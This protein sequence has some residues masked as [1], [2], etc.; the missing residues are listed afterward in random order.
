MGNA[1]LGN[2]LPGKLCF[3][4]LSSAP[5][6]K[7]PPWVGVVGRSKRLEALAKGAAD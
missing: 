4:A 7:T 1:L 6:E 2:A 5:R 3:W